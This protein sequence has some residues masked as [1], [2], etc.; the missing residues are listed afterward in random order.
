M[1]VSCTEAH[2]P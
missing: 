2:L 1:A